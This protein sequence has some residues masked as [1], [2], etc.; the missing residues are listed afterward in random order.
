ME[1]EGIEG[2]IPHRKYMHD[3]GLTMVSIKAIQELIRENE[4]M[5]QRILA[6]ENPV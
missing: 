5:K 1:L 2:E 4:S 6:L 3:E